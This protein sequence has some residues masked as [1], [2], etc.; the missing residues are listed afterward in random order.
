MPQRYNMPY[1]RQKLQ[2]HFYVIFCQSAKHNN[3][4]DDFGIYDKI[5]TEYDKIRFFIAHG[6]CIFS[7]SSI[8]MNY[9]ENYPINMLGKK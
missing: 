5:K 4:V 3:I 8:F 6:Y 7:I 1:R 2:G 9:R